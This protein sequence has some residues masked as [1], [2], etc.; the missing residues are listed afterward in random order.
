MCLKMILSKLFTV[1]FIYVNLVFMDENIHFISLS[2]NWT[3][4]GQNSNFSRFQTSDIQIIK[5][6][7]IINFVKWMDE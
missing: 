3:E 6:E 4:K 7:K 1:F 2:L 5:T